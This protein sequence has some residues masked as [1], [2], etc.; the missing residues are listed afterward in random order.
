MEKATTLPSDFA[1]ETADRGTYVLHYDEPKSIGYIAPF[2]G[3]FGILV[4]AYA[5]MV[6]LGREGCW[7]RVI[8]RF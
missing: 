8:E 7:A 5:Y 4:R 1:G 6:S 2:Y 3:N